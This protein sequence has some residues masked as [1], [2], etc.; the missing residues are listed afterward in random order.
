MSGHIRFKASVLEQAR[1]GA[2]ALAE[3]T[4]ENGCGTGKPRNEAQRSAKVWTARAAAERNQPAVS[5]IQQLEN[6][7][8]QPALSSS[9][10]GSGELFEE[11][12]AHA[13][14]GHQ[15]KKSI[16]ECLG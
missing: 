2:F 8:R 3:A 1:E 6:Q 11:A 9:K 14:F 4:G 15:L 16:E 7:K 5:D 10:A 13:A 12:Y